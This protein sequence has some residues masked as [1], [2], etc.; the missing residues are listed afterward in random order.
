MAIGSCLAAKV[1]AIGPV[2]LVC[3]L[4]GRRRARTAATK[5]ANEA[6]HD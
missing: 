5:E 1:V 6:E 4:L 3:A 2:I